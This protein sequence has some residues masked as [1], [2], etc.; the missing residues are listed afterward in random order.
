MNP[1][2]LGLC[3]LLL[4]AACATDDPTKSANPIADAMDA[5]SPEPDGALDDTSPQEDTATIP[6][7]VIDDTEED[8]SKQEVDAFDAEDETSEQ[9]PELTTCAFAAQNPGEQEV[10]TWMGTTERVSFQVAGVPAGAV[11]ARLTYTAYDA[12]HPG[13]E[14]WIE[15]NGTERIALP[16]RQELDNQ[17]DQFT[18]DVS[19]RVLE[20][21]NTVDFVAFDA[22]EGAYF[23]I[24]AV[25]LE[26]DG[27][28]IDCDGP[29]PTGQGVE[30]TINYRQAQYTQRRNWVLDCRDYAY[31]AR[32][33]EHRECDSDYDPDGTGHGTA[34]FVFPDVIPDRYHVEVEG[35]HTE[36][37]NPNQMLVTVNGIGARIDQRGE[38]QYEYA[39]HG[40]Y[41][42]SGTVTVIIDS[43]ASVGSDSV[44]HVRLRPVR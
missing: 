44:R 13:A 40:T 26:I 32:F 25:A 24:S 19:D 2:L 11:A 37:R 20:G 18:V 12:D 9:E 35:R 1:Q 3:G 31:S 29:E 42:L 30:R 17:S 14:G 5:T 7:A 38:G 28:E 15:I 6:D 22:P 10:N 21:L 8:T 4:V 27:D 23:R 34:T 43:T 39:L 16:A 36:N 33:D 41:D